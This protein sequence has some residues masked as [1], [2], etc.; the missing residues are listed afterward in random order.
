MVDRRRLDAIGKGGRRE[1][2]KRKTVRTARHREADRL[3]TL[4]KRAEIGAESLDQ[5]G[6]RRGQ[7]HPAWALAGGSSFA[8]SARILPW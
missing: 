7:L 4:G 2:Q 3:I 5:R 6:F 8:T 1:Q